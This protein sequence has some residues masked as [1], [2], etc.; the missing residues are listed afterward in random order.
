MNGNIIH[1]IAY[2]TAGIVIFPIAYIAGLIMGLYDIITKR[3]S[4]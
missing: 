1:D 3:I 2:I 4:R